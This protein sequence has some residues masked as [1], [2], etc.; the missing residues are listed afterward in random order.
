MSGLSS[1]LAQNAIKVENMKI[2]ASKRF[3]D[4]SGA[5]ILWEARC[6]T[7]AEDEE[8]RKACTKRMRIPGRKNQYAPETDYNEYLGRLAAQCTVYPNL[9]DQGL[10]DSY[11]VMG[12]EAL[13]KAMLTPGEYAEYLSKIQEINGFDTAFE[14]LVEDAKN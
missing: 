2:T 3:I 5:P 9:N 8:L 14:D 13:L 4:E 1:F 12:A 6:I 7:S 11:H 10:Q